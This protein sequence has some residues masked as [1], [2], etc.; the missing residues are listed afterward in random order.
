MLEKLA[1]STRFYRVAESLVPF[2]SWMMITFP[3]WF[4]LFHPAVVGYFILAFF[5]YF[6]YKSIKNVY[7]AGLSYQLIERAGKINWHTRL[8]KNNKYQDIEHYIVIC[9]YKESVKK[10]ED[11]IDRII[12]QKYALKK[13]HI[14]LAMEDREGDDAKKR[15]EILKNKYGE[16]FASFES[17][18]HMMVPGEVVGKASNE[19]YAVVKIYEKI[20]E[21]GIDPKKVLI[22]I[23][24]ADSMLP[25]Q[26]FAY[27]TYEYLKDKDRDYHFYWAPVLLYNNFWALPLPVRLQSILSS[28]LRLAFLSQRDD[29]IQISTYTTNLWLLQQV[30]Y[31]DVDII[32]E[33]WHIWLQAFFKFGAKVKTIPIY[34]PI[35]CDATLSPGLW[36]TFKS[37][38]EQEMRWAW[39]VSDIP[40]A[41]KRSLETPHI[42]SSLK[43]NKIMLLV[44]THLLWPTSFFILTISASIPSIVNPA[45][46]RT[47]MGELLPRVSS[48]ILTISSLLL[49]FILY[50]D[51]KMRERVDVKTSMVNLPLLFVQWFFLPVISF[52][53][54]SLP[55][56]EAHT[57]MLLGKKIEYKVTEKI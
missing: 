38:Y 18:F 20:S 22:T 10:L 57:R 25:P 15:G 11:T 29:L 36:N 12:N 47:V 1:N 53:L 2:L 31:W 34:L 17:V 32:P 55:A 24:D 21:Q 13:I 44:E 23:C 7:Y 54:S 49:I 40:Y 19:S 46:G 41:I 4:S 33:D 37:R 45:F 42:S 8:T 30:G 14:V 27:T 9:N 3:I 26:Y 5:L 56:L 48:F 6:L 50:F 35:L 51:Y 43:L 39:G 28:I 16:H 52:F